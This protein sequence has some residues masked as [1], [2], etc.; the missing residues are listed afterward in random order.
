[1]PQAGALLHRSLQGFLQQGRKM[2]SAH[3]HARVLGGQ[4]EEGS[5]QGSPP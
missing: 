2:Q 4:H 5:V 3:V 1:M